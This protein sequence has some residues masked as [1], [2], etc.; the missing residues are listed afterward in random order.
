[1]KEIILVKCGEI[2]LK[3]LNRSGFEDR[4]V[5]NCRRRLENLGEFKFRKAQS[6]IYIEPQSEDIDLDE[7][8]ARLQKVFGIVALTRAC[9]A[10]KN[11][12][13]ITAKA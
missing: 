10:E 1:M 5:K 8:V 9:V 13:D 2:A 12:E 4:L 6:T 11:W 7:A 3:G